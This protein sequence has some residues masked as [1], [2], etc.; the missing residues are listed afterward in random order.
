MADMGQFLKP[1]H[2][3][4]RIPTRVAPSLLMR[5]MALFDPAI[6]SIVPMLGRTEMV[7]N[8]RAQKLLGM[9]FRDSGDSIR[10]SGDYLVKNNLV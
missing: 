8:A 6:R 10:H 7:S 5:V 1:D 3:Q 2:P 9:E 4:R